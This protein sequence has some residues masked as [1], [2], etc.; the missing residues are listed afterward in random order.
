[1]AKS[2]MRLANRAWRT[3]TKGLG[4]D[5]GWPGG[6]KAWKNFC[7]ANAAITADSRADLGDEPFRNQEEANEAVYEELTEWT[8]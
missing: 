6:R 8:P 7:R 1:M 3:E 2:Q 5:K 4:W